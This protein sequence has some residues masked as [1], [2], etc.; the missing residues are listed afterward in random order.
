VTY[1]L[2]VGDADST[3][4]ER[5][6]E[7]LDRHNFAAVGR[8]DLRELTVR[9]EDDGELV[10]GLSGWTWGTSAGIGMVWVRDADRRGGWGARLLGAAE[11]EARDR[12]C[13][14]VLVSSFTFQARSSTPGTA[15]SSSRGRRT[16]PS[17][18]RRTS[19]SSST[20]DDGH[21]GRM[22]VR[23][24]RDGPVT[25]VTID[26]PHTRNAVD[27][28]T[29]DDLAD[30][31]EAFEEDDAQRVA[32]LAGAG[33][34]FCSGADLTTMDNRVEPEG[35]G[36][37]G[38]TRMRLAK[39]VVAAIEGHAVAGGLELAIWCDLRVAASDAVLGVFCR[40]WGVPLVDGGTVRLPRLVGTGRALD[41][42][43]TGRE[44]DAEEALRIGLVDRVVDPGTALDAALDLARRLAALP[45][46]CLRNDRMS[47]LAAEGRSVEDAMRNEL[48][49][50][51]ASLGAGA[52]EGA[53]RF[54]AGSGRHGAPAEPGQGS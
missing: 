46:Q 22:T 18:V 51:L 17:R 38:P 19:T 21:H 27:R 30:A 28:R 8:D 3:L 48:R 7:E 45:Q 23:S 43:L 39:P 50:G 2:T 31:F 26:R 1:D 29:A 47:L 10:A 25:V 41:L 15:T 33:G 9:V 6:S 37:M 20:C 16:C 54:A 49:L 42:V 13:R 40:R 53:A 4:D 24:E 14:Q 11:R 52:A 36:P 32:V 44:V 35:P 5:L 34:T 12:G